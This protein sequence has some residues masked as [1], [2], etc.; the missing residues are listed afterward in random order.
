M[1]TI[2]V[3]AAEVA[4]L[5]SALVDTGAGLL[6]MSD[7][8]AERWALGPGETGPAVEELLGGW[9]RARLALSR[10]LVDVGD[11]AADAGSVYVDTETGVSRSLLGGAW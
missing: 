10:V 9:R 5:G 3:D 4:Q 6:L 8:S 11:A 1:S 7:P 2:R